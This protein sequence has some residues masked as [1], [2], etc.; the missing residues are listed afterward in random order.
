MTILV[1]SVA[2]LFA[3][4]SMGLTG[5]GFALVAMGVLPYVM[6][7]AQAN[8]VVLILAMIVCL[9]GVVPIRK[10]V[11]LDVLRPVWAGALLGTPLGVF[12][13]VELNETVLRI[14]LG[15]VI[16]LAIA[17]SL[18]QGRDRD[19]EQSDQASGSPWKGR[20]TA[21][22]VGVLSGAFGGAF[23]VGGPPIVLYLNSTISEKTEIKASLFGFF[24]VNMLLRGPLLI[25]NGIVTRETLLLSALSL[26]ALAVGLSVGT[27]LHDRLE[28]RVVR[29]IIQVLLIISATLL[30]LNA[31]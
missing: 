24:I 7:V 23:S 30:I 18:L 27:L 26:P 29:I 17:G 12:Y 25:A 11:R 31:L 20:L 22:G 9:V 28:T 13:L 14:S 15:A 16:L 8:G 5:F 19:P 6:T 1:V 21:A 2:V 3:S 10:K 4:F